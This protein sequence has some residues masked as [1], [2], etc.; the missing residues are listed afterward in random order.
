MTPR[1]VSTTI[2]RWWLDKRTDL[3]RQLA[4]LKGKKAD[5]RKIERLKS[6]IER[7]DAMLAT[8]ELRWL[9]S[10]AA[11]A[12]TTLVRPESGNGE[13]A[14]RRPGRISP[15][16]PTS[17]LGALAAAPYPAWIKPRSARQ[18]ARRFV[19]SRAEV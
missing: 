12:A 6:G 15:S 2:L 13:I 1:N 7:I 11:T 19:P 18:P 5:P 16:R 14:W 17:T 9:A 4:A 3:E 10:R 8:M